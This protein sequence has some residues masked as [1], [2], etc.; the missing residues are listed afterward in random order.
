M[1]GFTHELLCVFVDAVLVNG[2]TDAEKL[3]SVDLGTFACTKPKV[4]VY[5]FQK[6]SRQFLRRRIVDDISN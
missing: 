4:N 2:K 3:V 6:V 1:D 5:L